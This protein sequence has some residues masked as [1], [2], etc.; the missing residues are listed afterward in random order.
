MS[1]HIVNDA[2]NAKN[3]KPDKAMN[4]W[5]WLAREIVRVAI[6]DYIPLCEMYRDCTH[7]SRKKALA[8]QLEIEEE[9]FKGV[10]ANSVF[11]N[12]GGYNF[13][14]KLKGRIL[15]NEEYHT[16]RKGIKNGTI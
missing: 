6:D 4:N 13:I 1:Y 12:M 9:F 7:Y 3:T 14:M 16:S 10:I 2:R 11:V 15:N 8:R 5:E